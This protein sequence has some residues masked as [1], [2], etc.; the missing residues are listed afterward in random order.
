MLARRWNEEYARDR[1]VADAPVAFV[2]T[3]LDILEK[4]RGLASACSGL[5]VGCGNGR[6]YVPMIER[7]LDVLGIDSSDVAISQLQKRHPELADRLM[8]GRFEEFESDVKFDYIIA[9]QMFQHGV[10]QTISGYFDRIQRL[11]H[12][13]WIVLSKGQLC[14]N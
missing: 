14:Y 1:Y 9:I 6:N 2:Q 8:C 13:G 3:I 7:G 5:Y 12:L 10:L 11:L 4:E